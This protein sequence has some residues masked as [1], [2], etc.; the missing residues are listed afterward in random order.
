MPSFPSSADYHGFVPYS[1]QTKACKLVFSSS[2]LWIQHWSRYDRAQLKAQIVLCNN[3]TPC[4]NKHTW[5]NYSI[6]FKSMPIIILSIKIYNIEWYLYIYMC[7]C[8]ILKYSIF[9]KPGYTK[10]ITFPIIFRIIDISLH[11]C[12]IGNIGNIRWIPSFYDL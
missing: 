2:L 5:S 9:L 11:T 7:V 3:D 4:S 12:I 8:F 10:I 1:K 6:I